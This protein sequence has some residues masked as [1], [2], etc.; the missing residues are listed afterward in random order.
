M[1]EWL[2]I[3]LCSLYFY[4]LNKS[5]AGKRL[6]EI[7]RLASGLG[8]MHRSTCIIEVCRTSKNYT[9]TYDILFLLRVRIFH[10]K[11]TCVTVIERWWYV[12]SCLS[13]V[14]CGTTF[15]MTKVTYM[16]FL[17]GVKIIE[18]F[19]DIDFSQ[20]FPLLEGSMS[21]YTYIYINWV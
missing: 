7:Q 1:W 21:N 12:C 17:Q 18:I 3:N 13:C 2:W 6:P 15:K 20:F 5:V 9:K 10:I 11:H 8:H 19:Y 4:S 14:L 16:F